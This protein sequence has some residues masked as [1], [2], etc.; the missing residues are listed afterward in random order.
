MSSDVSRQAAVSLGDFV[1]VLGR[2]KVAG[3]GFVCV[4]EVQVCSAFRDIV[5]RALLLVRFGA[6]AWT[7]E[8]S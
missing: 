4:R 7:L 3:R 1:G 5:I 8:V 2:F 6:L